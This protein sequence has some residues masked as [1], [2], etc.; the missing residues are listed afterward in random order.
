MWL[1]ILGFYALNIEEACSSKTSVT[2]RTGQ[3]YRRHG[4]SRMCIIVTIISEYV[5]TQVQEN[6]EGLELNGTH[7]LLV[8]VD[9]IHL[10]SGNITPQT[11]TCKLCHMLVMTAG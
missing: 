1:L 3:H 4:C 2:N 5:I 8:C 6:L 11:E 9:G 7:Q 10:I